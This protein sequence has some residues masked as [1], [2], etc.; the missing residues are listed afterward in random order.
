MRLVGKAKDIEALI[1]AAEEMAS[2]AQREVSAKRMNR[3][4]VGTN[5]V[6]FWQRY[7]MRPATIDRILAQFTF[8]VRHE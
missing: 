5:A 2:L 1:T 8:A 3:H 7:L 6:F 4:V